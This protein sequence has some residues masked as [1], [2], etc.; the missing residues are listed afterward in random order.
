M[1]YSSY[2]DP[3]NPAL[4]CVPGLLGGPEDFINIIPRWT[5]LFHIFILDPNYERRQIGLNQLSAE[6]IREISFDSTSADIATLMEK[7]NKK[8]AALVGVSL[9]GKIVYD[10]AI[11]FPKLLRGALITDVGPG[12]FEDTLLYKTVDRL[13]REVPLHLPWADVKKYLATEIEDRPLRSL[14]QSQVSYPNKTPPGIWKTAMGNFRKMLQ[15]Q[16]IDDQ[17]EGLMKVDDFLFKEKRFIHILR[18][19]D[20]SGVSTESLSQIEQLKS[21]TQEVVPD[22][23]HFLHV[24]HKELLVD[25]VVEK[26]SR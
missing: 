12:S 7:E 4:I 25:R 13:V 18:A 17:F 5:D 14:I 6:T 3:K 2:G 1:H 20:L 11:K 9:G 8:D 23:T 24:T 21:I 16:S 26:F 10:F 15:K 19:V 22:S